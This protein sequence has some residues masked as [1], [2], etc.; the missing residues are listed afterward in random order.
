MIIGNACFLC[1]RVK[2]AFFLHACMHYDGWFLVVN[3]H[4]ACG[5]HDESVHSFSQDRNREVLCGHA[6]ASTNTPKRVFFCIAHV[7]RRKKTYPPSQ[8]ENGCF[9]NVAFSPFFCYANFV[10]SAFTPLLSFCG[11]WWLV[12]V[13]EL[14]GM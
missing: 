2:G 7:S 14:W 4:F 13:L 6:S 8:S 11:V 1:T 5:V 12:E 3:N 10:F 9:L